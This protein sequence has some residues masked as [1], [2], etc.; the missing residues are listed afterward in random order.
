[1]LPIC[2]VGS[3]QDTMSDYKS[4]IEK[5]LS[6]EDGYKNQ[7]EYVECV[8][9]SIMTTD[10]IDRITS[11]QSLI[12]EIKTI[13]GEFEF[14]CNIEQFFSPTYIV[15]VFLLTFLFVVAWLC[16]EHYNDA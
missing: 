8:L 7:P 16:V 2:E 13:K 10:F 12:D 1:M 15:T 14:Y 5:F 4:Q 6:G 3:V 11:G 9:K